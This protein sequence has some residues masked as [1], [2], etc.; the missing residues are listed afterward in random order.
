MDKIKAIRFRPGKWPE[1]IDVENTLE[2][3]QGQVGGY[4]EV[5]PIN[6]RAVAICNEEGRLLGLKP[7]VRILGETLVGT[8]L[9]V[10]RDG[11][12]FTDV[13]KGLEDLA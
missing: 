7:S 8:V 5:F 9:L 1:L 4:I 2:A 6:E 13:P 10:G 3:L 11:E 12:E